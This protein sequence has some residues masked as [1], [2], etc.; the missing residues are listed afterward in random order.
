MDPRWVQR[1]RVVDNGKQLQ[2]NGKQGETVC[3]WYEIRHVAY[4]VENWR[5][6]TTPVK[7]GKGAMQSTARLTSPLK[8]N[9]NGGYRY[10]RGGRC[11]KVEDSRWIEV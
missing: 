8:G 6:W 11:G 7:F 2:C 3:D 10:E 4:T 5:E 9:P 1:L